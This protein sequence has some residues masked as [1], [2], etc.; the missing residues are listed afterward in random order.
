M[1][2]ESN[3]DEYYSVEISKKLNLVE[4]NEYTK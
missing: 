1:L 2:G 4:E 3:N